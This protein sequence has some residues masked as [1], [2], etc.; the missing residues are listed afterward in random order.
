MSRKLKVFLVDDHGVLR[1]GMR[2]LIDMEKDMEVCG[3]ASNAM[4][5]LKL[6]PPSKPDVALTDIG[7]NGM[8]GLE[9]VKNLK[10]RLPKLPILVMSMFEESLYA[11]RALRAGARGYIMKHE[12]GDKVIAALR[13]V[14]YGKTYL[15]PTMSERML[16]KLANGQPAVSPLEALSDRELEV[17]QL[18]GEGLKPGEIAKKLNLSAKTVETYREQIKIK[19]NLANASALSQYAISWAKNA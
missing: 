5:A 4:E 13:Q 3:E 16:D 1:Q 17:F 9:L 19:L 8:N 11:E 7:L 2:R 10:Q 12:A 14:A 15:S 18:L 6:V